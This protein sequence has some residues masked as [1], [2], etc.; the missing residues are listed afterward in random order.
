MGNV[1]QIAIEALAVFYFDFIFAF[2]SLPALSKAAARD[3]LFTHHLPFRYGTD[4][5][6]SGRTTVEAKEM[7]GS[8]L[9]HTNFVYF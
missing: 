7:W 2:L 8:P 9:F 1:M 4:I 5:V 3:N 6:H